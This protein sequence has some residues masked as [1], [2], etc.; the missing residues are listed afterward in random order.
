M[1]VPPPKRSQ[2][3]KTTREEGIGRFIPGAT[4][5]K[6]RGRKP[7]NKDRIKRHIYLEKQDI[8]LLAKERYRR[9]LSGEDVATSA[10][11]RDAIR[12]AYGEK[13]PDTSDPEDVDRAGETAGTQLE[14]G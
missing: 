6:K 8:A 14:G 3:S 12:I 5:P 11:L 1:K 4:V 7:V 2:R 13:K 10:M 9:G